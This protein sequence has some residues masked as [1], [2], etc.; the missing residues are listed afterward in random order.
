[1]YKMFVMKEGTP[2]SAIMTRNVVTVNKTDPLER[3][4]QYF[5]KKHIRHIP[6]L[7]NNKIAGMLSYNDL[8]RISFADSYS[9]A[10]DF[11]SDSVYDMF[12]IDQVMVRN[13]IGI[14]P[15][16]TVRQA[17]KIFAEKEFHAL[18]VLEGEELVGILTTTDII[19]F[20]LDQYE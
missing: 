16:T 19:N 20:L 5:K 11:T 7:Q 4:E 14:S 6:V 13:V 12:S 2:I 9:L 1:M 10:D 8:L 18:P 3:A 15:D 17:A